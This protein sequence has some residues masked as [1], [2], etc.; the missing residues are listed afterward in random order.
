MPGGEYVRSIM[1]AAGGNTKV[2]TSILT[3]MAALYWNG[4]TEGKKAFAVVFATQILPT[5]DVTHEKMYDAL[6]RELCFQVL[7]EKIK[8]NFRSVPYFWPRKE[9]ASAGK[10]MQRRLGCIPVAERGT[11]HTGTAPD[12]TQIVY[13][14]ETLRGV[15]LFHV[16]IVMQLHAGRPTLQRPPFLGG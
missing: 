9:D 13:S 6:E 12:G 7:S 14:I 1:R 15:D 4:R 8:H 5:G 3:R 2:S 11:A 16:S 10:I